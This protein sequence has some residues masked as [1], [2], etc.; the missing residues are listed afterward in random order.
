MAW[1]KHI[2]YQKIGIQA[3]KEKKYDNLLEYVVA[4]FLLMIFFNSGK[5]HFRT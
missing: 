2:M 5:Y 4:N 3:Y 1:Y